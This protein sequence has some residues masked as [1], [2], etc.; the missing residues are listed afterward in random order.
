[1]LSGLPWSCVS[2]ASADLTCEHPYLSQFGIYD[3]NGH[4]FSF[5]RNFQRLSVG[6]KTDFRTFSVC[7]SLKCGVKFLLLKILL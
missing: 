6:R 4:C 1:V 2:S 7:L 3:F 5:G